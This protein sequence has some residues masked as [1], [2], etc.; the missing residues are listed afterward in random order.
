MAKY[1]LL[2]SLKSFGIQLNKTVK[3]IS[4]EN[5]QVDWSKEEILLSRLERK[6]GKSRN[7]L[8]QMIS[9]DLLNLLT[10]VP[11]DSGKK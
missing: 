7:E 3:N 9:K 1:N 5:N 6:L 8:E 11:F 2:H 4:R 10:M